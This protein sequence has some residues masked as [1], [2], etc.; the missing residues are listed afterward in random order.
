MS[1]NHW[2]RGSGGRG[3]HQRIPTPTL[4][5]LSIPLTRLQGTGIARNGPGTY[6]GRFKVISQTGTPQVQ[7]Y[8]G[9]NATDGTL[10]Q[11]VA[12]PVTGV[13]NELGVSTSVYGLWIVADASQ[14]ID[15]EV[16]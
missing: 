8:N 11:T 12:A 16:D 10:L 3:G 5:D 6:T 9:R 7:V 2:L 4:T 15:F 1:L 14:V 13:W